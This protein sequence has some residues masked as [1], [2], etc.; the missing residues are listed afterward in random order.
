MDIA[1]FYKMFK[2]YFFDSTYSVRLHKKNK[3]ESVIKNQDS[4]GSFNE[5][6]ILM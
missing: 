3:K 1:S 5:S 2:Y 6:N 4:V